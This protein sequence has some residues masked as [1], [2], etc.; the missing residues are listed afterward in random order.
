MK[1]ITL[2]SLAPSLASRYLLLVAAVAML[3]LT[4]TA[5]SQETPAPEAPAAPAASGDVERGRYLV[6]GVGMCGQCH[7]PRDDKGN[8]QM[9]QWLEGAVVPVPKPEGYVG[10][11]AY[12]APRISGLPQHTDEEFVTLM[13]TGVNRDGKILMGPMP[14]FR[15]TEEDALAIAAY[16]RTLR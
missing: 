1:E 13:T 2:K 14:P 9:D 8:L 6:E 10:G 3:G 4:M 7:S 11:W 16:L 5:T 12:K 15:L